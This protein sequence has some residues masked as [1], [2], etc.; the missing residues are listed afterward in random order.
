MCVHTFDSAICEVLGVLQAQT[1]GLQQALHGDVQQ[2][3]SA[4]SG[5]GAQE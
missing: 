2:R 4:V 3:G 1:D 5:L